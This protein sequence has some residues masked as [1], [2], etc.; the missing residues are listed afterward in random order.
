MVRPQASNSDSTR[1]SGGVFHGLNAIV[2]QVM[3]GKDRVM[4]LMDFLGRQS[5]V[6]VGAQ[7][8]IRRGFER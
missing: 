4:V 8:V 5:S 2:T 3:P 1:L 6:M 7:S